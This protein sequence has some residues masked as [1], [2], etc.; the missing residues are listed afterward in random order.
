MAGSGGTE[1]W[2]DDDLASSGRGVRPVGGQGPRRVWQGAED[3]MVPFARGKWLAQDMPGAQRRLLDDEGHLSLLAQMD[4][5]V[6]ELSGAAG[7][8]SAQAAWSRL[9]SAWPGR[10]VV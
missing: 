6:G 3:R 10:V 9:S 8:T 5:I 7:L 4:G 2:A 1:G